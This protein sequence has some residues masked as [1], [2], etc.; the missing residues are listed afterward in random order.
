MLVGLGNVEGAIIGGFLVG[1][2]ET[3][4]YYYLGSGWQDVI[5]LFVLILILLFKPSGLFGSEVKGVWE[6]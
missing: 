1:M 4:S 6:R 3:G 5:T 2:L